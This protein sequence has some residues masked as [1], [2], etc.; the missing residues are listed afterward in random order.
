MR[1][2]AFFPAIRVARGFHAECV[3][4][5]GVHPGAA[6][7]TISRLLLLF[8]TTL[9]VGTAPFGRDVAAGARGAQPRRV[10]IEPRGSSLTATVGTTLKLS[11]RLELDDGSV[12]PLDDQ[13]TWTSANPAV[14]RV[15]N[16]SGSEPAGA[17]TP[18]RA[19][20]SGVTITYPRVSTMSG[21]AATRMLGDSVTIVVREP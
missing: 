17:V 13:V 10:T 11:A 16:G 20:T 9:V 12:L 19:G 15:A 2:V 21:F 5:R 7:M 8:A 4:A 14:L 1:A 18:L 6:T 3:A